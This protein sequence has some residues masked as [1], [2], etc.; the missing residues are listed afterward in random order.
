MSFRIESSFDDY[1]ATL[2]K[3]KHS[4]SQ[5]DSKQVVNSKLQVVQKSG[6]TWRL[7]CLASPFFTLFNKDAYSHVR[8]NVVAKNIVRYCEENER[9]F[10]KA[11]KSELELRLSILNALNTKTAQ[12]YSAVFTSAIN[13]LNSRLTPNPAERIWPAN[14][15]D[16]GIT[17][18]QKN[19]TELSL[20]KIVPLLQKGTGVY[21]RSLRE[22][23]F[24]NG[25]LEKEKKVL[26]L[27]ATIV[28]GQ[29]KVLE[30][31]DEP[32]R[33]TCLYSA[34]NK[35][36]NIILHLKKI[37]GS[38]GERFAKL[39]YDLTTGSY[40]V[41]KKCMTTY[42]EE[43]LQFLKDHKLQGVAEVISIR[44]VHKPTTGIVKTQVLEKLYDG[45]LPLL[46][47]KQVSIRQK[48]DLFDNL[49]TGLS[50]L[51]RLHI[52]K[53][54]YVCNNLNYTYFDLPVFHFDISPNNI[55][56][57][58]SKE[59]GSWEAVIADFGLA[60]NL[61]AG[62]GTLGYRAPECIKAERLAYSSDQLLPE[63]LIIK[64]NVQFGQKKDVWSMGLVL[65][66]ILVGYV[67]PILKGVIAPLRSIEACFAVQSS[68][69]YME[70]LSQKD[71]DSDIHAYKAVSDD[72]LYNRLWDIVGVMLRVDPELRPSAQSVYEQFKKIQIN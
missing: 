27:Q 38:G 21:L 66:V 72:L 34:A 18:D 31:L 64:H 39:S 15:Y 57:R 62:W 40:L 37:I 6:V 3:I 47:T 71:I 9:Y 4:L 63:Q 56:V 54:N 20:C 55:L 8:A 43:L 45:P 33:F 28:A 12:K 36:T 60:C 19:R 46:F 11:S 42:E 2:Q 10:G 24:K 50:N 25:R 32:I 16:F 29:P 68:D 44:K 61:G 23:S 51:H 7:L 17:L 65:A 58:L 70:G 69:I 52:P 5:P 26:L 53:F 1:I 22:F 48:Y 13:D 67:S 49:L 14:L 35:I 41:R 30:T 59:T